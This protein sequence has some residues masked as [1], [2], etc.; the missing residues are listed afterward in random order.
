[1]V[2]FNALP[3]AYDVFKGSDHT[4]PKSRSKE[5]KYEGGVRAFERPVERGGC[6]YRFSGMEC[7]LCGHICIDSGGLMS[8]SHGGLTT[9]TAEGWAT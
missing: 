9:V 6:T 4:C 7:K 5:H 8:W 1:M 3:F 2:D